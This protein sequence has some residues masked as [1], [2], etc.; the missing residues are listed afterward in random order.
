MLR[1]C[2]GAAILLLLVAFTACETEEQ[3]AKEIEA[4]APDYVLTAQQLFSEYEANEVAADLKYKGKV[5]LVTGVVTDIGKDIFDT[6]FIE[7]SLDQ[8]GL[9]GVKC[10]FA[11]NEVPGI[12]SISKG[13]T[14][15]MK[16]K[17]DGKP[18]FAVELRGC[19]LE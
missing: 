18:I 16:G 6:P 10:N 12:A 4:L 7:M 11:E 14:L 9:E 15:T 8:F 13:Q 2:F 5:L 17:G 19:T 1:L 3:V